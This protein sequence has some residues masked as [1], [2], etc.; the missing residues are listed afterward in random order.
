MARSTGIRNREAGDPEIRRTVCRPLLPYWCAYVAWFLVALSILA[1]AFFT[2]L[3]SF[4]I[5]S[6][7]CH[8]L[9][10]VLKL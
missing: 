2:I 7:F 9:A 8:T 3:Y 4:E 6:L 5:R 10:V 1:S